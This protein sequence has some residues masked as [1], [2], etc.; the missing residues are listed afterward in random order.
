MRGMWR[1]ARMCRREPP[2]NH[3]AGGCLILLTGLVCFPGQAGLQLSAGA[4]LQS[5]DRDAAWG[6]ADISLVIRAS[7]ATTDD[8]ELLQKMNGR[9]CF[10]LITYGVHF[11]GPSDMVPGLWTPNLNCPRGVCTAGS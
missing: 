3:P 9:I 7:P 2:G 11:Q 5:G 1:P 6:A 4:G 8:P 10:C